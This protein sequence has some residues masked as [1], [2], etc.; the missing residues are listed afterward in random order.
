MSSDV[1]H[2]VVNDGSGQSIAYGQCPYK[3]ECNGTIAY[4]VEGTPADQPLSCWHCQSC[5]RHVN[6][7]KDDSVMYVR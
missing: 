6:V 3:D 7:R 2:E 5:N 1:H 4:Q